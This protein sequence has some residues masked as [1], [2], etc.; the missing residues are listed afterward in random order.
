M[1]GAA[2][3]GLCETRD[4]GIM[5]PQWHS[6]LFEGQGSVDMRLVRPRE[7]KKMLL[8]WKKEATKHEYEGE[9]YLRKRV[10]SLENTKLCMKKIY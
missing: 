8:F 5:W 9:C 6:L 3:A 10:T 1:I 4:F 7:M 2:G